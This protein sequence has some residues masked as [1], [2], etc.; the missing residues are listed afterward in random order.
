MQQGSDI[1]TWIKKPYV[2]MSHG[3]FFPTD[4]VLHLWGSTLVVRQRWPQGRSERQD[5]KVLGLGVGPPEPSFDRGS[6]PTG[7][8][9]IPDVGLR[10]PP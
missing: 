10:Y 8:L 9:K 7:V 3:L 2:P 5:G 4:Q 1:L 6:I